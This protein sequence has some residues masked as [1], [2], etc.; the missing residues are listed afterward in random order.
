MLI[1]G[2]VWMRQQKLTLVV[3]KIFAIN[4]YRHSHFLAAPFDFTTFFTLA[5]MCALIMLCRWARK[6]NPVVSKHCLLPI[7]YQVTALYSVI[8]QSR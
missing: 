5:V 2:E 4:I 7:S 3:I 8:I 6:H 1:P